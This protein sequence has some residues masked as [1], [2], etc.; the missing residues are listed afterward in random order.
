MN[1]M[2]GGAKQ[3]ESTSQKG[4]YVTEVMDLIG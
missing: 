3:N 4:I 2:P 1:K